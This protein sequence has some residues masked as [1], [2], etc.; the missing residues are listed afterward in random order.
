M[1][2]LIILTIVVL[3][4]TI[5]CTSIPNAP[6]VM[7]LPG[8]GQSLEQ[9]SKDNI[10][11]QQ[12]ATLQVSGTPNQNCN[13][14]APS[15]SSI[16]E[17]Q[18]HYDMAYIQCM[19]IKGHQVPVYGQFTSATPTQVKLAYPVNPSHAPNLTLNTKPAQ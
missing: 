6:A 3:L 13:N 15:S 19:Y 7:V 11:C 18:L 5:G 16:N 9:F 12:F 4:T 1:S 10:T 17:D 2:R 14:I 8:S